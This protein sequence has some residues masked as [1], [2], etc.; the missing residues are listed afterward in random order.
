[1]EVLLFWIVC[2]HAE[3]TQLWYVYVEETFWGFCCG[4]EEV[5][6]YELGWL[7]GEVVEEEHEES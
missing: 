6:G 4:V 7:E 5:T 2:V 1:M 3:M